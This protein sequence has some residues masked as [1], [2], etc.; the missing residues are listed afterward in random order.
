MMEIV[1]KENNETGAEIISLDS[2]SKK[3]EKPSITPESVIEA[4]SKQELSDLIVIARTKEGDFQMS[5]SVENG[6]LAYFMVKK[7]AFAMEHTIL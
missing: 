1:D 4:I 6:M 5:M 3:Q 7:A 2:K